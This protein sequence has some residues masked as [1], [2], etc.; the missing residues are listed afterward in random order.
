MIY[1]SVPTDHHGTIFNQF[2]FIYDHFLLSKDSIFGGSPTR[3]DDI[4]DDYMPSPPPRHLRGGR[5]GGGRPKQQ[6]QVKKEEGAIGT[7]EPVATSQEK[8]LTQ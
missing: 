6:Q 1:T 3:L 4:H 5:V 7:L 2:L 8:P